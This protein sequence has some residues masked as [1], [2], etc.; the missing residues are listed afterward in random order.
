M[1]VKYSQIIHSPVLELKGQT[2]LGVAADLVI[3]KSDLS[4]KAAVVKNGLLNVNTKVATSADIVELNSGSVIV[5]DD[6][7][8]ASLAEAERIR[9]AIA[10][11]MHGVGQRVRTKSGKNIGKVY[12]YTIDNSTCAI[13][14]IYVKSLLDDRI[15]SVSSITKF[16]GKQITVKD[17]FELITAA[18]PAFKPEVA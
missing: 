16:E 5:R 11:K 18:G 13:Q 3:Q 1:I 4:V 7:S 9:E 12:D 14:K 6:N 10:D 8:L 17:D 15:I 2:R